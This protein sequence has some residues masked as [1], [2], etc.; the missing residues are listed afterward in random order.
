MKLLV[1]SF[2]LLF[3]FSAAAVD[4]KEVEKELTTTGVTGWIHGAIDGQ[5]M[6]V[7][8]YRNPNDFFD[9]IEMS[10]VTDSSE[11][12]AQ[13]KTIQRHD[14]VKVKGRFLQMP[15]PQKHI[16]VSSLEM[17]E[18]FKSGYPTDPYSYETKI[19]A[20][21][22]DV[23]TG[24]FLVHAVAEEGH[25]LVV[26]YKDAVLPI[27]V[28]N[29]LLAKDL[30]RGDVVQMSISLQEYPNRPTHLVINETA[31]NPLTVVDSVSAL[32]GKEGTIE[33]ALI[34]FPQSPEIKFNVFAVKQDLQGGLSR[35]FTLVNFDDPTLFA[36]IRAALQAAWDKYPGDYVNGRNKLVS[37][38]V[39]VR[40][41]GTFNEV[42]Q[43]QANPQILLKTM[44]SIEIE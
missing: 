6:Y 3:G 18:K 10:L 42:S 37:R 9:Y 12:K 28:K 44:Q 40:A 11:V 15:N 30:Y 16:N 34:L 29:N 4:M 1:I 19:P 22:K 36:N 20:D 24:L 13:L 31:P 27:Y 35:Q 14:K 25:I 21:L 32:N 7:F 8:T 23:T 43:S 39:R 5:S 2:A 17:V 26:E 41:T 33:G 38:K